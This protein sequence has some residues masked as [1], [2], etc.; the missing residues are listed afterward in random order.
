MSVINWIKGAT[1]EREE[2]VGKDNGS[3]PDVL[4]RPLRAVL[5][6]SGVDPD[7]NFPG[8]LPLSG[9][10]VS[11]QINAN[12]GIVGQFGFGIITANHT[13][14][15]EDQVRI[16]D[17]SAGNIVITAPAASLGK[18]GWT[19][20]RV[21]STTNT[22]TV[23]P[24]AGDTLVGVAT[25]AAGEAAGVMLSGTTTVYVMHGAA[26][27]SLPA[28]SIVP[29]HFGLGGWTFDGTAAFS[30]IVSFASGAFFN[31]SV[32]YQVTQVAAAGATRTLSYS[33]SVLVDMTLTA[34][35]TITL[36][37]ANQGAVME[38]LI[39]QDA[40]GSRTITWP[41]AVKL[42]TGFALTTAANSATKVR[43]WYDGSN[44]WLELQGKY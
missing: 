21:D 3:L 11:G 23:V 43:L 8:F 30:D 31:G 40:T 15:V 14:S 12:G 16:V 24:W 5:T 36:A 9:G 7:D 17:A 20:C 42:P 39:R 41:A 22:V 35:C 28:S 33:A 34:N 13:L 2:L 32:V 37:N 18:Y 38:V 6:D 26:G 4:N 10:S 27:G 19:L 29:G 44:H 1:A 25:I